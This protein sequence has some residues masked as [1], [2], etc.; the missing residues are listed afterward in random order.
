MEFRLEDGNP[1]VK[2]YEVDDDLNRGKL[3][4]EYEPMT[5]KDLHNKYDDDALRKTML[6]ITN[7]LFGEEK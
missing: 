2:V 1:F 5:M 7:D 6:T 3:V 4:K